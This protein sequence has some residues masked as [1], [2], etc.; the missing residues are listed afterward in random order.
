MATRGR[1]PWFRR[2]SR[3]IPLAAG[4]VVASVVVATL[5]S[6]WPA[7][8]LIRAVFERGA[9]ET[10][11]TM[12][13]YDPTEGVDQTLDIEY[14]GAGASTSLDVFNPS[15]GTT[16]LPTVVWIHG[17]AWI[18]GDKSQVRPYVRLLAAAG[19]TA[20][21]LNYGVSPEQVYPTALTQ[22]ND[23][24]AFL[25]AHAAEYRIDPNHIVLAGDS[26]GANLASQLAVLATNPEYAQRVG[27]R[28]AL[29]ALQ[30]NG[31]ILN[32]GIYD[33]SGIP[34]APGIVGW[35]FRV[36]LWSYL[37]QRDWLSTPGGQQMS[38]V[39]DVTSSFPPTWISGG[40]DDPLTAG[41][42]RPLAARLDDLGVEVEPVFYPDDH[43]P[44]LPHEYQFHLNDADARTALASTITWLGGVTGHVAEP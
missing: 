8:L 10:L 34:Q 19:Y 13:P 41:Q 18:S 21:A 44:A 2:P 27:V 29:S 43:Q 32:C 23:A 6:P 22:L 3:V 28:P 25:V 20:V 12:K 40:N 39:N 14:G 36:A 42:S 31:V 1:R 17:G 5:V 35:G 38:T 30:L 33:V 7:A 4:V 9:S 11:A 37:G 15:A 24:L 16:P 26:A